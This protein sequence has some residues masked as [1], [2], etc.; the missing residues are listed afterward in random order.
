MHKFN[1]KKLE[2]LDNSQRRESMPPEETLKKLKGSSAIGHNRYSTTGSSNANNI[3]PFNIIYHSGIIALAHNGNLTNT[4]T[5][6][7]QLRKEGAIFQTTTDSELFMHLIA[8]SKKQSLIEQIR[9]TLQTAVGSYSLVIL[10]EEGLF[11]A[12]DPHGVRPLSIGRK[13]NPDGTYSF[14]VASESCAFDINNFEYC[15]S[16]HH[17]ELI[18]I[19]EESTKTGE[20]HSSKI[21]EKT[22]EA[23]HCIFEYVYFALPNSMIFGHSVD[24]I[25]RKLGKKLAEESPLIEPNNE[26]VNVIA[27][28]DSANTCALG[29][30]RINNDKNPTVFEIGLLRSHYVGR[31]FIA[32]GQNNREFKVKVKFSPVSGVIKDRHIVLVDDSIVRGTTSKSLVKI[33]RDQQPKSL[34]CRVSSPRIKYPCYYGMDF[35]SKEELI[36]NHY[37]SEEEIGEAIGVDSLH[38]LSEEKLLE[39]VPEEKGISYCTA[40]FTGNYPIPVEDKIIYKHNLKDKK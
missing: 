6:R 33:I 20:V 13:T 27:V 17:N 4:N 31:T 35:P 9:E 12:R 28:P 32:P 23:H 15:R 11:A 16:I 36:A 18:L 2:K 39:S 38:F 7:D 34:H 8:R 5:L 29:Y 37:N 40:C 1:I 10:T 22:P 30:S 19:N 24:K 21:L 26:K 3:Q 25:R 14:I